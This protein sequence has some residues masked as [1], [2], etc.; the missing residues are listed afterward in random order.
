MCVI[1]CWKPKFGNVNELR[2]TPPEIDLINLVKKQICGF[3]NTRCLSVFSTKC[4]FFHGFIII[5]SM[6]T[7]SIK[8]VIKFKYPPFK[9]RV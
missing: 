9:N 2:K 4:H 1:S 3:F 7:F 8:H 5:F 6:N